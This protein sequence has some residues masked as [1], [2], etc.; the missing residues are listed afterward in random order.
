MAA[1]YVKEILAE[2]AGVP[3][4]AQ[5]TLTNTL[6]DLFETFFPE[7]KFLGPQPTP[8]GALRFPVLTA[9]GNTHD[10]D[11]LSAGE[12]EILYGYLRIRNS[13]P[14]HSIILLDE[15]ELHLNP[16]LIRGLPQFYQKNL[17][18]S[19]GNQMWLVTH[20]DALLREVVGRE[21]YNVFHMLP[22]AN[23]KEGES[24]LKA[25]SATADLELALVDLVGDLASYRPGGKVVIFEGGGDSDFDQKVAATLY[26][27]LQREANL[28]SGSNKVRVHALHETL[29]RAAQ[30]GQLPFEFFSITD[31]DA[32][33]DVP[34]TGSVN[35]FSWD[36]YHIENYFL[37]PVYLQKV[38]ASLAIDTWSDERLLWDELRTCAEETIPY[39]VRHQ[40]SEI[41]NRALVSAINLG[42]DP[43]ASD[44]V[45]TLRGAIDRSAER[46]NKECAKLDEEFLRNEQEILA[47]KYTT[48]LADG[49][50]IAAVR[51]R[52]VLKR[53]VGKH[54]SKV[55]Y[56]VFRTLLLSA[57]RDDGYR[58]P[59]MSIIIDR[60]VGK[61]GGSTLGVETAKR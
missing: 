16:R 23:V 31:R 24:Q 17:G 6:K 54:C 26:P 27:E 11:E 20:S 2:Q 7:K 29:E 13:A 58:P 8:E 43:K 37:V 55:S 1:S 33:D 60:I 49:S 30:R 41:A 46:I 51:G 14:R 19:L 22:C 34:K 32:G 18:E 3:R 52:D 50:W 12:K 9:K 10:L 59:G 4:A 40:L 38:L 35:R 57:M 48:S 53:F 61:T 15:P 44:V 42:T 47:K 36:V 39:L 21:K 56:E 28:I 5:S 25:L 45:L